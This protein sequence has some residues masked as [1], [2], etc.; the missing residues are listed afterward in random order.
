MRAGNHPRLR[1]VEGET[2]R[3]LLP[4]LLEANG[5]TWRKGEEPVYIRRGPARGSPVGG[6][7]VAVPVIC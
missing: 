7:R 5:V 6:G 4:E 3:R 1:L 2:E